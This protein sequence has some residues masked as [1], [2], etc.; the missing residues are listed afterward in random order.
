[1]KALLDVKLAEIILRNQRSQVRIL[2]GV[3]FFSTT[4]RHSALQKRPALHSKGDFLL[5][6]TI[7][8]Y[9]ILE[10]IG[11]GGMGDA[12]RPVRGGGY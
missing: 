2:S 7:S 8:H 9:K 12:S 6:K 4:Y 5:G 3:P 10:K 11:E 1:M